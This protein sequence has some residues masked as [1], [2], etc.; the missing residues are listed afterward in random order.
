VAARRARRAPAAE[1][2]AAALRNLAASPGWD[3]TLDA[4]SRV[5][6]TGGADVPTS[7]TV[8]WGEH[9]RLLL[10]RQAERARRAAPARPSPVAARV[11]PR[12]TWDDPAQVAEV[13]LSS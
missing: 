6:F 1:A 3:A 8:A 13:I 7:A 10:P 11:R 5:H 2:Y 12:P 9:D 4:M